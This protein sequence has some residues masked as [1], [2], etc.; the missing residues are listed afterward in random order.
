MVRKLKTAGR[1]LDYA[2]GL[3]DAINETL[4]LGQG[5]RL[6]RQMIGLMNIA[7]TDQMLDLG[8]GT[9]SLTLQIAEQ[10]SGGGHITGIDAVVKM[11]EA[12]DKKCKKK[13]L[14]DRCRFQA[15][16]AEQLPF[17]DGVFDTCLSS[18]FYHHL[19][20]ELKIASLSEAC[21]VLKPGGSF[22][23]IDIDRPDNIFARLFLMAGYV[24]LFQPAIKENIDGLLPGLI[25]MAGFRDLKLLQKKWGMI[26]VYHCIKPLPSGSQ[27]HIV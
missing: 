7:P 15:E 6:R 2:A 25:I 18:M 9:G 20:R 19:P 24:C 27:P 21:R 13:G 26:S 12:A 5:R 17:E 4:M 22:V 14:Q 1:T 16:L 23:T 11:I 10:L 8:C 3:Y